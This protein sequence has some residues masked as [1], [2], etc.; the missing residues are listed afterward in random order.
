MII[1]RDGVGTAV[2]PAPGADRVA[3]RAGGGGWPAAWLLAAVAAALAGVVYL[4]ALGNPFVYDDRGNVLANPSIRHLA[5]LRGVVLG[6]VFRPLVNLS[7]ALDHAV[8]GLAPFGYHLTSLLL[9]AAGVALLFGLVRASVPAGGDSRRDAVAFAAAAL[10]AVH[11]LMTQAVGYASGRAEVLCGTLFLA[12][13]GCFARRLRTGRTRWLAASLGLG[14]LALLAKEVAVMYP[15]VLLAYDRLLGGGSEEERRR[16]LRRLHAPLVLLALLAGA[17][18]AAAFLWIE[19][20]MGTAPVLA[21]ALAE[22]GVVWRYLWLLLL[23]LSQSIVHDVRPVSTPLAPAT[24]AAGAALAGLVLL[25][26]LARRR[27]PLASFGVAWFLLLLVPSSSVVPLWEL[28]AEQRAYLASAG[29]FMVAGAG[30]GGLL[31]LGAR[32]GWRVLPP[33][34]LAGALVLLG[35]LTVSRNRVWADPVRLWLDAA[36]QAP[37]SW[38]AHHGLAD[39]LAAR[40]DCREAIPAYQAALRLQPRRAGIHANLGGCLAQVGRLEEAYRALETAVRLDPALADAHGNLGAVAM[41]A[42]DAGAAR[43]HFEDAIRVDPENVAARQNLAELYERVYGDPAEALRLCREVQ[44]LAP[45]AEGVDACIRR[46]AGRAP[47]STGSR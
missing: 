1:G 8:W 12:S 7:Y 18:R 30:F 35:G 3:D 29:V 42:R 32:R 24:L 13:L 33:V 20:P 19:P 37:A 27:A 14:A 2:V 11:P 22:L 4:N 25:T 5:D 6:N 40:G 9:H 21:Y 16:R 39:A 36:R 10:F 45:R 17:A 23:P 28:M 44:S 15:L 34:A 31:A 43:R 41:L 26:F 47:A 38:V 46:N